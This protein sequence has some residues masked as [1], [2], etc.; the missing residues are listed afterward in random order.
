MNEEI[1]EIMRL[2]FHNNFFVDRNSKE[3]NFEYLDSLVDHVLTKE[4]NED[5]EEIANKI[6]VL[7]QR[8]KKMFVPNM[9]I[10]PLCF[11]KDLLEDFEENLYSVVLSTEEIKKI[12]RCSESIEDFKMNFNISMMM[13]NWDTFGAQ[14]RSAII[15]KALKFLEKSYAIKFEAGKVYRA[16][17]ISENLY[18]S[19][20]L[21]E[22]ANWLSKKINVTFSH[23]TIDAIELLQYCEKTEMYFQIA[24]ELS[25]RKIDSVNRDNQSILS[26]VIKPMKLGYKADKNDFVF[27]DLTDEEIS[28]SNA[29]IFIYDE[30]CK[31]IHKSVQEKI[32]C[33]KALKRNVL[34]L[35]QKQ[36]ELD[37][38]QKK[39]SKLQYEI[40]KLK[41]NYGEERQAR[42]KEQKAREREL[43]SLREYAFNRTEEKKCIEIETEENAAYCG[44]YTNVVIV[45]GH[46]T[47]QMKVAKR[48]Q[49]INTIS[50]DQNVIDWTFMN[51]MEVVVIVI[52]HISHSMYHRVVGKVREQKLIY[53]DYKNIDQ[54]QKEIDTI[55]LK[56][57][58]R[59]GGYSG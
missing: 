20:A 56:K 30:L 10:M 36:E 46:S 41:R 28:I 11:R 12:G 1:K 13:H 23:Q 59:K 51:R 52:N 57:E 45:G 50:T 19:I 25:K 33:G 26:N 54:L 24:E 14:Q 39:V 27:V 40:D 53:L 49:G 22:F 9:E 32:N 16:K 44:D 5:Y 47:W 4:K 37:A 43:L 58:T 15:T 31:Y 17:K 8:I 34:E 3:S 48:L 7:D 55:L 29:Y 18:L 21:N 35:K 6:W 42:Q 38:L 2:S